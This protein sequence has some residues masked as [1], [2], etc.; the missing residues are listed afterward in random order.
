M[1]SSIG[2]PEQTGRDTPRDARRLE[3]Q[4]T[5]VRESSA[6]ATSARLRAH[7]FK[8]G[9]R[10]RRTHWDRCAS[11][12]AHADVQIG[13][14]FRWLNPDRPGMRRIRFVGFSPSRPLFGGGRDGQVRALPCNGRPALV[15]AS[16]EIAAPEGALQQ[17]EIADRSPD[18]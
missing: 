10:H 2:A 13:P 7:R 17:F 1:T 11:S 15:P 18:A 16:G 5:R 9:R 3:E 14:R 6:S 4:P 8:I 12:T